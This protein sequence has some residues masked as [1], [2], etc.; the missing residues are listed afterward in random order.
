MTTQTGPVSVLTPKKIYDEISKTIVGQHKA[1]KVVSNALYL[2]L[3]RLIVLASEQETN[4]DAKLE[5]K[6]NILLMGPSGCGKTYMVRTAATAMRTLTGLNIFNMLEVDSSRL[7]PAGWEGDDLDK[8]IANFYTNKLKS[9]KSLLDTTIVYLDEFDKK[10]L[11][12]IGTG[13]TDHNKNT[14]YS[15]LKLVEGRDIQVKDGFGAVDTINTTNTLFVFA[16]NF[17]DLRDKR[18]DTGTKLGFTHNNIVETIT[19]VHEALIETGVVTELVGRI[20]F[21]GEVEQ[22]SREELVQIL[23]LHVAPKTNHMLH[24][25]GIDLESKKGKFGAIADAAIKRGTGA[26]GLDVELFTSL[27]EEIFESHINL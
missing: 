10:A 20:G 17:K 26:R 18:K 5:A 1:K 16:G 19:N 15:L 11:P 4:K 13:G 7:S 23:T 14:Q 8:E 3:V 12:A 9:N 22:L 21:V 6:S 25:I 24:H 2:H 27:E